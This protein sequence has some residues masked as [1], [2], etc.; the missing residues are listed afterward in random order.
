MTKNNHAY[1][2]DLIDTDVLERFPRRLTTFGRHRTDS[3]AIF[4]KQSQAQSALAKAKAGITGYSR[5]EAAMRDAA[6]TV[7]NHFHGAYSD[8]LLGPPH[9]MLEEMGQYKVDDPALMSQQ[10]KTAARQ[11]GAVLTGISAFDARWVY[12]FDH[13]D[14][15]LDIPSDIKFAITIAVPMDARMIF[16]APKLMASVTTGAG[17]SRMAA[18]ASSLAQFIRHLGYQA[19]AMM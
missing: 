11:F 4:Y 2:D 18:T 17:Y 7:A 1:Q 5:V 3:S 8:A 19:I 15:A 14:A 13:K 9:Y 16:E 10:I 12:R 6:W